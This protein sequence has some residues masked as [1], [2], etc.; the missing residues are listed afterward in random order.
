MYPDLRIIVA[1]DSRED[2]NIRGVEH[3]RMPYDSGVSAGRNLALS[4]VETPFVVTLDDD[5]V[6]VDRT[7]LERWLDI[8]ENT[9]LDIIGGN[10]DGHPN[11]HASLQITDDALVFL[12]TPVGKED[13]FSLWNIVLQFWMGRTDKIREIG[14]WDDEFK[15]VDHII[16]FARSIGK[17]KIGYCPEVGAGHIPIRNPEYYKHRN[18]RMQQYLRLLMERLSV[19]R[20]IDVH[21]RTLYAYDGECC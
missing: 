9:N 4:L 17:I 20:V 21:G 2:H 15:T 13:G 18:G 12:P 7:R 14:G 19:K 11:Y 6:F 3:L 1:D 10:V 5:F 16:F 8:L